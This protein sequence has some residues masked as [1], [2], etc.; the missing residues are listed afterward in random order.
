VKAR[1]RHIKSQVHPDPN[2]T[3]VR[4]ILLKEKVLSLCRIS[5]VITGDFSGHLDL[6][7][8]EWAP[9]GMASNATGS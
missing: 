3:L 6:I 7:S 1:E 2:I 9:A 8:H 4:E 5:Q